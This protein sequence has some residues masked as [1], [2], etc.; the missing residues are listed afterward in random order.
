MLPEKILCEDGDLL[1][2]IL[3]Y[4]TCIVIVSCA[5]ISKQKHFSKS[6]DLPP[7]VI[8]PPSNAFQCFLETKTLL[9]TFKYTLDITLGRKFGF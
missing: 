9:Q 4:C 5:R 2:F 6:F 8:E 1:L 3:D 7:V